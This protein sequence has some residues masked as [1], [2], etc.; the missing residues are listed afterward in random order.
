MP[1][2]VFNYML[3]EISPQE[4]NFFSSKEKI[5]RQEGDG[6]LNTY[7]TFYF[8]LYEH[9][10]YPMPIITCANRYKCF[11]RKEKSAHALLT[12]AQLAEKA[13]QH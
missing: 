13:F 11:N 8:Q 7:G 3:D 9:L 4:E 1:V 12:T 5:I 10:V 6:Q 2:H